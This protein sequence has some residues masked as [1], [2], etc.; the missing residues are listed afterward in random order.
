MHPCSQCQPPADTAVKAIE[1]GGGIEEIFHAQIMEQN[2]YCQVTN[3]SNR[4]LF[5]P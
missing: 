1:E 5:P 2:D 3:D 4:V